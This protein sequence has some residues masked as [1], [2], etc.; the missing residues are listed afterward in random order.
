MS[1]TLIGRLSNARN[2]L[3]RG[4]IVQMNQTP[5]AQ[6]ALEG[7]AQQRIRA[8][9]NACESDP[10][11]AVQMLRE[12]GGNPSALGLQDSL[13]EM[14]PHRPKPAD[15]KLI[16]NLK[17]LD[18]AD[19]FV[20]MSALIRAYDRAI[21]PRKLE[22]AQKVIDRKA[23]RCQI[24]DENQNFFHLA[25]KK[26]SNSARTI[27]LINFFC[28][29]V[30][31][32]KDGD[33]RAETDQSTLTFLTSL[34][35]AGVPYEPEITKCLADS[36][37]T[38][39]IDAV[40]VIEGEKFICDIVNAEGQTL[41]HRACFES[42]C[43]PVISRLLEMGCSIDAL[44]KQNQTPL[45]LA[46]VR[47]NTNAVAALLRNGKHGILAVEKAVAFRT[48]GSTRAIMESEIARLHIDAVIAKMGQVAVDRPPR[49]FLP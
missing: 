34:K 6:A 19:F 13:C 1:Q 12:Q 18:D 16:E 43:D 36:T 46:S 7:A 32:Q 27:N 42:N 26:H 33:A 44:D 37:N 4:R 35:R 47:D 17:T 38:L 5:V 9:D 29:K 8:F 31:T 22:L 25:Q 48:S 15:I 39:M 20:A 14:E 41:L 24:V 11:L 40:A 49:P 2:R 3:A 23:V 45:I 10:K 28:A 21:G 30:L